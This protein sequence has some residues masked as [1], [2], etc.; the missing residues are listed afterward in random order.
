D[1]VNAYIY[2]YAINSAITVQALNPNLTP[3][4]VVYHN[5]FFL[6]GNTNQ[7]NQSSSW[8]AYRFATN[9]TIAEET[10]LALQT[11]PDFPIAIKRIPGQSAHVLVF[12][13]TVC[14]VFTQIGGLQNYRRNNSIS[15]DYGCLSVT[16]IDS[17][18]KMIAWLAVN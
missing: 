11:K 9:T 10:E 14:E 12:G 15:I 2:N 4:Y 13:S 18:N 1:G 5:T 16:T 3:N 8:F 7:V 17:S 6:F